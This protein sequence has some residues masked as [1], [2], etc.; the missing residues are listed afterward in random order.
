MFPEKSASCLQKSDG[1]PTQSPELM[2]RPLGSRGKALGGRGQGRSM[3][4]HT[5]VEGGREEGRRHRKVEEPQ[6]VSEEF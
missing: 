6:M 3:M 1:V 4:N 5:S 2:S